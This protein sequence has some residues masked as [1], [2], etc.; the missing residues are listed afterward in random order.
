MPCI[1]AI[2]TPHPNVFR[3]ANRDA[4]PDWEKHMTKDGTAKITTR[5]WCEQVCKERMERRATK[6]ATTGRGK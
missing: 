6:A 2:P 1:H 3:C 5:Y 4:W